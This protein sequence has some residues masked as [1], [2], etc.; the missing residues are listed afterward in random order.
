MAWERAKERAG[1]DVLKPSSW[2][3]WDAPGW[4]AA[5]MREAPCGTL[6]PPNGTS[7]MAATTH[8]VPS[9][10]SAPRPPAVTGRAVAVVLQNNRA[11]IVAEWAR[12]LKNGSFA[13]YADV[14]LDELESACST[15]LS[16]FVAT[17]T[18][19]DHAKMRRFVRREVRLR[20]AQ[21]YHESE[22]DQLLC[23][24]RI[25]A[26]PLVAAE[27]PNDGRATAAALSFLQHCVDEALFELSDFYENTAQQQAEAHLAEMEAI[28]RRLEDISVRD[29]LTGLYNRRYFADRLKQEFDRVVRHYHP[30]ALLMFDIDH[31]KVVNDTH[32]HQAGDDVLRGLARVLVNKTRTTDIVCRYGGEE[33][34]AMLP[35][36]TLESAQMLAERLREIVAHTT[37]RQASAAGTGIG[38]GAG[39]G[40]GS[41]TDPATVIPLANGSNDG[42]HCTVSIGV[43]AFVGTGA[44]D[45][46]QLVAAADAALYAAK[47]SGRN[48]VV[49]AASFT[50]S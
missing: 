20:L 18:D 31:F 7:T 38:T 9:A 35:D 30:M 41:T 2:D 37:L 13:G 5:G 16:A 19:G 36:T 23:T 33:F 21:G 15:C 42:L 24:I 34:V 49:T 6:A 1:Q 45:P 17:L 39:T 47:N 22:I 8:P 26:W 28:N 10:P 29:G 25:P 46:E 44:T 4:S 50:A 32:G 43:A 12:V 48:R 14:P 11:E 40:T 27:Y 3:A